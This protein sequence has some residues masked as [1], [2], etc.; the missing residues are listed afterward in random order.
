MWK[1]KGAGM[2]IRAIGDLPRK[3]VFFTAEKGGETTDVLGETGGG[4]KS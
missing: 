1:K 2:S 4:K 3:T